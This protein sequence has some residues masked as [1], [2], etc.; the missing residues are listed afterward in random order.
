MNTA[1]KIQKCCEIIRPHFNNKLLV[2]STWCVQGM[3]KS[4][5]TS[6]SA[7]NKGCCTRLVVIISVINSVINLGCVL[8]TTSNTLLRVA[9]PI[10]LQS[11]VHFHFGR[12]CI[13]IAD[14]PA[15]QE[16]TSLGSTHAMHPPMWMHTTILVLCPLR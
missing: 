14:L 9:S 1:K 2:L 5:F 15:S 4:T 13:M 3:S 6:L 8:G 10:P 12:F 11:Q 7:K 16:L